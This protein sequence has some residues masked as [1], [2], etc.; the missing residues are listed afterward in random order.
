[1]WE[2]GRVAGYRKVQQKERTGWSGGG[3]REG[4]RERGKEG[5]RGE[6]KGR[7]HYARRGAGLT[8]KWACEAE[9]GIGP[10]L[11]RLPIGHH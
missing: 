11:G 5:G 8:L 9:C 4:R 1:M 2:W 10:L 3:G 7:G 6:K